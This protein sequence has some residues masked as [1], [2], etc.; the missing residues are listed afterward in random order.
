MMP[1]FQKMVI[2]LFNLGINTVALAI[3]SGFPKF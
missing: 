1:H 2:R 3:W